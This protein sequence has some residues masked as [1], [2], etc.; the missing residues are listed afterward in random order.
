MKLHMQIYTVILLLLLC[1]F[2]QIIYLLYIEVM[3]PFAAVAE[4]LLADIQERL[5]YRAQNFIDT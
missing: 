4:E 5:V 3:F 2:S 1:I